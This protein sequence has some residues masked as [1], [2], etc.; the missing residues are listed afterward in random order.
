MPPARSSA[1]W[2]TPRSSSSSV[3]W[4]STST[5]SPGETREQFEA[6][7]DAAAQ[8]G[9]DAETAKI[10]DRLEAKRDRLERALEAA[11][12]KVEE[13]GTAQSSR[14]STE[15]LSGLGSVVGVL[16]GG[17]ANSRTIA[18]AGRALGGAASRRGMTTRAAERKRTAEEQAESKE[19][20][21]E[22]LEQE[23]LDEVAEIDERWKAK[24][25]E[26]ETI[27]IGLEATDVRV[28]DTALVWVPTA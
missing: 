12:Q 2:R 7:A 4:S 6:R 24:A 3:A 22:T 26:I 21:L 8:T 25:D 27:A 23:L 5:L 15:L 9:A 19:Q 16:L 10:R 18:R 14:R 28:V 17:K 13:A 20:D 11:R 1:E